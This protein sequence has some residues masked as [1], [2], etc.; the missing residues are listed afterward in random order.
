MS[1]LGW[2]QIMV[3]AAKRV[4]GPKR[5]MALLVG[6][7]FAL[8]GGA[9]V[10]TSKVKKKIEKKKQEKEQEAAAAIVYTVL[11]ESRS[12]EGLFFKKGAKFKIL[13]TDGDTGLI[14]IIGDK[15]NPYIVSLKFLSTISD[16]KQI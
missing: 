6:G 11:S 3:E 14:E 2:Y 10:T 13:E 12:K 1:N 4:G 7:G 9:A 15:N 16:Y 5:F 8:G